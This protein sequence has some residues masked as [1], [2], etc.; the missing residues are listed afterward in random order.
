MR[1]SAYSIKPMQAY[2]AAEAE[3]ERLSLLG[4]TLFEPGTEQT[5]QTNDA[6]IRYD[7]YYDSFALR[8]FLQAPDSA[9]EYADIGLL[10]TDGT[11]TVAGLSFD[12]R[13]FV[14][15]RYNTRS[16]FHAVRRAVRK[17]RADICWTSAHR[18]LDIGIATARPVA[19]L[20]NRLGPFKGKAYYLAE[21]VEGV[22]C[23]EYLPT[24]TDQNE[25]DRLVEKFAALFRILVK[26]RLSHGD[27]KA[28]NFLINQGEPVVLDL[29]AMRTHN[30]TLS[31]AKGFKKDKRRFLRN[32][33]SHPE[34]HKRFQQ[35]LDT[36]NP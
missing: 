4:N 5:R 13:R 2:L 18:L 11:S 3:A 23:N 29:D 10:K 7:P 28:T 35:Q 1:E 27:T 9:V 21:F 31:L 6:F 24:L 30:N 22:L 15:K 16:L 19:I 34:L 25:T 26:H 8:Q 20:E 12:G 17:S 14:V 33:E 36:I 32:W